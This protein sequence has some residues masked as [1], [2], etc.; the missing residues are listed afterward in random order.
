M[1]V[2]ALTTFAGVAGAGFRILLREK[3]KLKRDICTSIAIGLGLGALSIAGYSALFE[4]PLSAVNYLSVFLYFFMFG[5][6]LGDVADTLKFFIWH[7]KFFI[8]QRKKK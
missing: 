8:R 2:F 4:L 5:Y 6:V 3:Y 1:V 7:R